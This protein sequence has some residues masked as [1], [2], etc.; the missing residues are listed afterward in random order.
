MYMCDNSWVGV[1]EILRKKEED[2]IPDL[3]LVLL[4]DI[5]ATHQ[6]PFTSAKS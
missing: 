3:G 4:P 2:K 1:A 6:I 5:T